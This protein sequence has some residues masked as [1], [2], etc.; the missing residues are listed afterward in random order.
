MNQK[1]SALPGSMMPCV[2]V[3]SETGGICKPRRM[4]GISGNASQW[5]RRLI[6]SLCGSSQSVVSR[7]W[8][9][10]ALQPHRSQT[11]K[12]SR[13]PLFVEKARQIVGLY[14]SPPD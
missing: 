10:F 7:V 3:R 2:V 9:D 4:V 13:A 14:L 1:R 8:R 5:S 11:L 12:L 6:P